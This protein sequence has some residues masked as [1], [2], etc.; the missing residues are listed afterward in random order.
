MRLLAIQHVVDGRE[1]EFHTTY[2]KNSAD[3]PIMARLPQALDKAISQPNLPSLQQSR[4]SWDD[5]L[6]IVNYRHLRLQ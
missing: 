3:S 1:N 5:Y 6:S 4:E 2:L